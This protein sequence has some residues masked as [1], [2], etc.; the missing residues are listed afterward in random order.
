MQS[1]IAEQQRWL[2]RRW[3]RWA[4]SVSV[5]FGALLVLRV[6]RA[7]G[8]GFNLAATAGVV[9][10][11][12][13]GDQ[14]YFTF[15]IQAR[16]AVSPILQVGLLGSTAHIGDPSRAWAAPGTDEQIWRF[17]GLVA[18]STSPMSKLSVGVR[19]TLGVFHS[20]G[21]VYRG[22]PPDFEPIWQFAD[23]PTGVTYGG[24]LGA[25]IGPFSRVRGLVQGNIWVDRA[26]GTSGVD[27]E[28]LFGVGVDL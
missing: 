6:G 27:I 14:S 5:L 1:S 17:A 25:E 11:D 2:E 23:A 28:L 20:S 10:Y 12:F 19:G 3:L 21:L 22:P 18:L 24:G 16:F 13:G 8:Q 7:E 4:A 9:K 26:Y 15:G